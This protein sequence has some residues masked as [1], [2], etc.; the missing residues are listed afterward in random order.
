MTVPTLK[1]LNTQ[2]AWRVIADDNRITIMIIMSWQVF[3]CDYV[4]L[5]KLNTWNSFKLLVYI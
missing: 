4:K 1:G 3:S 2:F 5:N